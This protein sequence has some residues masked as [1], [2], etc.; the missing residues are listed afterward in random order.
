MPS[1]QITH[2][3]REG[4]GSKESLEHKWDK[5]KGIAEKEYG[6]GHWG[7]VEHIYQNMRDSKKHESSVDLNAA[8][9]IVEDEKSDSK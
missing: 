7:A 3:A 8:E 5:A 9:R 4:K 6:P 1:R 2:D